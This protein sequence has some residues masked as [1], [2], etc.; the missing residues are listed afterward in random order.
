[1]KFSLSLFK[2]VLICLIIAVAGN[3]MYLDYRLLRS[4]QSDAFTPPPQNTNVQ[5]VQT[6]KV[7]Y[8]RI[9]SAIKSATASLSLKS[10]A[11]P[12]NTIIYAS[13]TATTANKTQEFYIP[14]GFGSTNSTSWIDLPGVEAYVAPDNYGKIKEMY[15]EAGLSIPTG[16]GQVFAR[17]NNVTDKNTLFESEVNL[18]GSNGGLVSS[19]KIPAPVATKLYRVQLKSSLGAEVKLDNARIKIFAQ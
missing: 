7:D 6:E 9:F 2:V 4:T 19:G 12:G 14:L 5:N 17:L 1:M 13:P 15:F 16:N 18:Q 10:G 11:Q 8:D 3:L